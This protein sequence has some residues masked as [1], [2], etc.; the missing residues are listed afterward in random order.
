MLLEEQDI[1]TCVDIISKSDPSKKAL[2]IIGN[3]SLL[4]HMEDPLDEAGGC[5][6]TFQWKFV[7]HSFFEITK[8]NR[9][10]RIQAVNPSREPGTRKAS[11]E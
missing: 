2:H 7:V 10:A 5:F 1:R 3:Q 8:N 9:E 11:E 6:L 4:H